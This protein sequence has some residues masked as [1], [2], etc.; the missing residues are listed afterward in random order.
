VLKEKY[1]GEGRN[2]LV[3]IED[4]Y[5]LGCGEIGRAI[6]SYTISLHLK[7]KATCRVCNFVVG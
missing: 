5:E 7:H 6:T 1:R 3:N 2:S 4:I